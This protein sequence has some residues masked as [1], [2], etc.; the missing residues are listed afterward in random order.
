[1]QKQLINLQIGQQR[2][3]LS[4][5]YIA[6]DAPYKAVYRPYFS[7]V[8]KA[9]N[10]ARPDMPFSAMAVAP[11]KERVDFNLGMQP[12]GQ[13]GNTKKGCWRR[14]CSRRYVN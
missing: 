13:N 8:T 11:P 10:A 6:S 2:Y 7:E 4:P 14:I 12:E 3:A 9:Y 1:M 5:Q